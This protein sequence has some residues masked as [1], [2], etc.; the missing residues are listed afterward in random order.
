MDYAYHGGQK[1][2]GC[3][4]RIQ[5][6]LTP[7]AFDKWI[8]GDMVMRHP[9]LRHVLKGKSMQQILDFQCLGHIASEARKRL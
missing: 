2:S 3:Q 8:V 7:L 1:R 9:T 5:R 4:Q 6:N